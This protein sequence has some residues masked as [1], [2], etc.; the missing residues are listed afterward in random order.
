VLAGGVGG[1]KRADLADAF[2]VVAEFE[3]GFH[4]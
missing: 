1:E 4:Q 3:L 2:A